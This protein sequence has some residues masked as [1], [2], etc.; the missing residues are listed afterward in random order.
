MEYHSGWQD[1]TETIFVLFSMTHYLSKKQDN[2]LKLM[3]TQSD[4]FEIPL[5]CY[6]AM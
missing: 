5:L 6:P 3:P 2:Q 1:W 4:N